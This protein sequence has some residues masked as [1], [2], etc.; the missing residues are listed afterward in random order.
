[1]F[2]NIK[3]LLFNKMDSNEKFQ[4]GIFIFL[5]LGILGIT[6][7]LYFSDPLA[8]QRFFGNFNPVLIIFFLSLLGILFLTYFLSKG[9]FVIFERKNLKGLAV[10]FGLATLLGVVIIFIDL[11]Y[12]FSEK[13]NILFPQ[14]LLF[15]PVMGYIAE[16]VFHIVPLAFLI[17]IFTFL[18][19]NTE[20]ER[21]I[22]VSLVF[23]ALLDPIFQI[24]SG[25]TG[26]YGFLISGLVVAHIFLVNL[27]EVLIFKRYDFF[28]MYSFRLMYYTYWHIVWGYLRLFIIY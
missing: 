22:L 3:W 28:T 27:V 13:I 5:S 16:I 24:S 11:I 9:Y 14:S 26:E 25:S 15:Y 12:P 21:I 10:S 8:F 19:K 4:L 2:T 7:I 17:V 23:V 20:K 1:M 6:A 18:F